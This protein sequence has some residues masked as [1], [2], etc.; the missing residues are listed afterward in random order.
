MEIEYTKC[1]CGRLARHR[2]YFKGKESFYCCECYV[3]AGNAPSDWHSECMS[4]Y[5]KLKDSNA[6]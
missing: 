6:K 4:T 3:K 1:I 2:E 5:K